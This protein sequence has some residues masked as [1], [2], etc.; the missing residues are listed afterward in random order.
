MI[1]RFLGLVTLL[2]VIAVLTTS[3]GYAETPEPE[4]TAQAAT[5][6]MDHSLVPD[7]VPTSDEIVHV[8][9]GTE[10]YGMVVGRIDDKGFNEMSWNG[11][12][13]AAEELGVHVNMLHG[14]HRADTAQSI[15]QF[16]NLGYDGIVTVGYE[17]TDA[18][19]RASEANPDLPFAIV[20]YPSQTPDTLGLLFDAD[21]PSFMAGYLA[22]G[23]SETG[24]VCTYGG[25][26]IPPVMAFMVGFENGVGYYNEQKGADINVLGWQSDSKNPIGGE[27]EFVGDF[28]NISTAR[29]LTEKL[30]DA[31]CDV[32]FPV[33][34]IAGRGTAEVAEDLGLIVIGVDSDEAMTNPEYADV[35]L[36][37]VLK[38]TDLMVLSAI[39]LMHEG[40]FAGGSN[41]VGTLE[42]GEVDL[43]PF[44]SFED[45]VPQEMKT[46]LDEIRQGLVDHSI[47][48]GWPIFGVI[49]PYVS[50]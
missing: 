11:M 5:P 50:E 29:D 22:A 37:S 38:R 41:F 20:D 43:A 6:E 32:V 26:H 8:H 25:I 28:E 10:R 12:E 31:E 16:I 19:R 23:M 7:A 42:N 49:K 24:T 2:V 46:D 33:A 1:G 40:T 48:T 34:G 39:A 47:S 18:T 4:A 3:V 13:I 15:E 30:A 9:M 36:T 45:K 17:M 14:F 21:E 27:G 35:Y 44:H